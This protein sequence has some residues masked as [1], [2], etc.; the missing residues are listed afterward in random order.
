ME[1]KQPALASWMLGGGPE[2]EIVFSSRIR[3][4]RNLVN[5]P[6][7]SRHGQALDKVTAALEPCYESL[8]QK[9]DQSYQWLRMSEVD[10]LDKNILVEKHLA[11]PQFMQESEN[12]VLILRDDEK[13][14]IMVNEEDHLRIQSIQSGLD[15]VAAWQKADEIDD[16]IEELQS[17]A[18]SEQFGYLTACPTNVGT[19]LRASCMLHLPALVLTNQINRVVSATTQLGLAVRG[20]YGEG[21]EAIGNMFQISNQL[22]LGFTEQ[23]ILDN[24]QTVVKQIVEQEKSARQLLLSESRFALQD[25]LWRAFG[26]LS[27]AR[28]MSG[29]EALAQLSEVRLGI[30]LDI[31]TDVSPQVHHELLITTRPSYLQ[32]MSGLSELSVRERDRLRAQVIRETLSNSMR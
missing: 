28:Q 14:S 11:S 24:L 12:R 21:T 23:E 22:T 20:L 19:G 17:Y 13:V 16:T 15:L 31:I 5:L 25:R 8:L 32:K 4:A 7:P 2:G 18:F 1:S 9:Q 29:Q 10:S 30:D 3:L 26:I 27:Y 6:F